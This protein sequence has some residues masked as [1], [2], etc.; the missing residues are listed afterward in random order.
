MDP[1]ELRVSPLFDR[2]DNNDLAAVS[3]R[4]VVVDRPSGAVLA[5]QGRVG[6]ECLVLLEGSASV[7]V[8]DEFITRVGPGSTVGEMALLEHVP[9]VATVIADTA[10]RAVCF[11]LEQFRAVVD[12]VPAL[13]RRLV[14]VAER[15]SMQIEAFRQG[16]R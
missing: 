3:H 8:G 14:E 12:E 10:I 7:Y 6:L 5:E 11:D 13:R 4:G 1:S 16:L 2:F 9:R 15:R